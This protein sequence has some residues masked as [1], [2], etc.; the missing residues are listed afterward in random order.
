MAY[1]TDQ[2][3]DMTSN[4]APS[5][6]ASAISELDA[7]HSAW[8]AM[9]DENASEIC[10]HSNSGAIP[11]WLKYQFATAK[12]ISQYAIT[13]RNNAA[14]QMPKT[15]KL[16]GSNNGTGW[17][18]L[19]SQT[20]LTFTQAEKKTFQFSNSTAYLYYRLYITASNDNNYVA[21]GEFELMKLYEIKSINGLASASVKSI[22]GLVNASTKIINGLRL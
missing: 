8:K 20:N 21:I 15:W 5:G 10:W 4:T 7:S 17:T 13:A 9:D 12:V 14:T 3:P 1:T 2:I 18:D 11:G 16:Q 19:D 22:N 6:V